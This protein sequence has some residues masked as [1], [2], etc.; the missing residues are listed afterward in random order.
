M[1]DFD[2]IGNIE[3]TGYVGK[4]GGEP[5]KQPPHGWTRKGLKVSGKYDN[6]NDDWL[7]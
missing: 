3:M 1:N 5:Y 7:S 2:E 6:G 4:R